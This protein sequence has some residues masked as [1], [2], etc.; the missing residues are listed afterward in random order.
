MDNIIRFNDY[1]QTQNERL[2]ALSIDADTFQEKFLDIRFQDKFFSQIPKIISVNHMQVFTRLFEQCNSI[3]RNR[4]GCVEGI[5]D[6]QSW[7]AKITL[8]LPFIECTSQSLSFLRELVEHAALVSFFPV[9]E[10][11]R[12]SMEIQLP[13]F[14]DL[15][16]DEKTAEE[17]F[18]ST[19][20]Y[21]EDQGYPFN[22][23]NTLEDFLG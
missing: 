1:T 23:W 19:K 11:Q 8:T 9:P 5:I 13:I 16:I 17:I 10:T 14:E 21:F 12:I 6:F 7:D 20:M 18:Q 22:K 4:H 2:A 3:A 15:E